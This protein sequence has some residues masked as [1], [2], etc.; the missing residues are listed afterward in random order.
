MKEDMI[1][2][3]WSMFGI[4]VSERWAPRDMRK[5]IYDIYIPILTP[6]GEI[7]SFKYENC[8]H[9]QYGTFADVRRR[10]NRIPRTYKRALADAI[11]RMHKEYEQKKRNSET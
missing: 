10:I 3:W 5:R 7:L 9:V 4:T 11:E 8:T 2:Y 1:K 6:E